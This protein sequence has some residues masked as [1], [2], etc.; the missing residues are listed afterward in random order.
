[1]T[2]NLQLWYRSILAKPS[3]AYATHLCY[4][5]Y[6]TK[7]RQVRHSG[8]L[9]VTL[10]ATC[11]KHGYGVPQGSI[12]GPVLFNLCMNDLPNVVQFSSVESYVDDTKI[13][14]CPSRLR[15]LTSLWKESL[16]TSVMSPSGA[17][18]LNC[19]LIAAKP[20]SLYLEP[21]SFWLKSEKLVTWVFRSLD[22]SSF[23]FRPLRK[24]VLD[25][26]LTFNEHVS[27]LTSSLLSALC[28]IWRVRQLFSRPVLLM[29]LNSLVLSKLFYCST[30]WAGTFKQN[31]QSCNWS[32]TLPLV[33]WLAPRSS[34]MLLQYYES[35]NSPQLRFS[36]KQGCR[37]FV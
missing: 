22:K 33:L 4:K 37:T 5:S 14:S 29:I 2:R 13:F 11:S 6:A 9:K 24:I 35:Y 7:V 18:Q 17:A 21:G 28:Q 25:S 8:G 3:I 36:W 31:P 19:W 32:K 26:Y 16:K 12:L 10:L 20:N 34:I 30:V 15:M 27:C 23:L 1:M